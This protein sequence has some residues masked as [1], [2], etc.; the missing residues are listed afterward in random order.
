MF[1]LGEYM[2]IVVP[3]FPGMGFVCNALAP[4][5]FRGSIGCFNPIERI[6]LPHPRPLDVSLL[7]H[8]PWYPKSS[9]LRCSLLR[10]DPLAAVKTPL[11]AGLRNGRSST[12]SYICTTLSYDSISGGSPHRR[13]HLSHRLVWKLIQSLQDGTPTRFLAT[14]SSQ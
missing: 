3:F 12:A 9:R 6:L 11:T 13:S 10:G 8:I 2:D 7:Q 14:F 4:T 5:A 1:V